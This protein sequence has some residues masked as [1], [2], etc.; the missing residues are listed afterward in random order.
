M[1]IMK[2]RTSLTGT[3]R[4]CIAQAS[5]STWYIFGLDCGCSFNVHAAYLGSVSDVV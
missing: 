5:R 3:S 2:E 4:P 1:G